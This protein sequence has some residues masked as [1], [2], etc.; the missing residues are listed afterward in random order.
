[1][2]KKYDYI[3]LIKTYDAHRKFIHFVTSNHL[4][5]FYNMPKIIAV[6]AAIEIIFDDL[7]KS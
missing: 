5:R 2:K 6:C 1:M 4:E 7:F 3:Y